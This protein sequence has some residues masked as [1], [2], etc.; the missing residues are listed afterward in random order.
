MPSSVAAQPQGSCNPHQNP[1]RSHKGGYL[2]CPFNISSSYAALAERRVRED[3]ARGRGR[4]AV[5]DKDGV[6][7]L[8]ST[9]SHVDS[10]GIDSDFAGRPWSRA[11]VGANRLSAK[12]K[13]TQQEQAE[14]IYGHGT[15]AGDDGFV[16]ATGAASIT[17]DLSQENMFAVDVRDR[18]ALQKVVPRAVR[19]KVKRR[20]LEEF[21]KERLSPG[22]HHC[23]GC[24]PLHTD[25]TADK[26]VG[27]E[28][29][30]ESRSEDHIAVPPHE[31]TR[32]SLPAAGSSRNGAPPLPYSAGGKAHPSGGSS[33]VKACAE[34]SP[35]SGPPDA[36]AQHPPLRQPTP[37]PGSTK[38]NCPK[39][40]MQM[41]DGL[42]AS[43]LM[44]KKNRR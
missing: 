41:L 23:H 32:F 8:S 11:G 40:R 39:N 25:R 20:K 26:E 6:T 5:A 16:A 35:R 4:V 17:G 43:A 21:K 44:G 12:E 24:A 3:L 33:G 7:A 27:E 18:A 29:G 31:R 22:N 1:V 34:R 28:D 38:P 19:E 30:V 14:L 15:L 13:R 36:S 2:C 42:R 37:T 10:D 9:G